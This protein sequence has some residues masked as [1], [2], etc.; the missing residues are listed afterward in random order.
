ML[1]SIK[2]RDFLKTAAFTCAAGFL[3]LSRSVFGQEEKPERMN[4]LLLVSEDHGPHL[5][6][7]GDPHARTPN[8]DRFAADGVRFSNAYVTAA[9]C[10][11]SRATILTGLYPEQHGQIGLSISFSTKQKLVAMKPGTVTLPQLLKRHGYTT[12]VLGKIHVDPHETIGLDFR[13]GS[14]TLGESRSSLTEL[15]VVTQGGEKKQSRVRYSADVEQM[16]RDASE[17][18]AHSADTPFFLMVN[19]SDA[20]QQWYNQVI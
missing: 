9:S 20:H 2:R 13:R 17:F 4:I 1:Q 18:F 16:T 14:D 11:P 6:C 7:Y 8:L 15:P 12:G 19:F 5:G 3:P 10:S